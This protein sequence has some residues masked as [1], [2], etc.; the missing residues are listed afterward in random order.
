MFLLLVLNQ[1]FLH[2]N[3]AGA[4]RVAAGRKSVEP[5]LASSLTSRNHKL[6]HL[7]IAKSLAMKEKK[8]RNKDTD[9]EDTDD[10]DLDD[11]VDDDGYHY[12]E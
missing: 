1:S 4:I 11:L 2:R 9:D 7:F 10:D 12:V 6:D 8:K 5:S 3:I